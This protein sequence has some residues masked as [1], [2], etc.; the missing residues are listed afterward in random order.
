MASEVGTPTEEQ[1]RAMLAKSLPESVDE[2]TLARIVESAKSQ[3]R[4]DPR[5]LFPERAFFRAVTND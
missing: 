1:L 3:Q 4:Q 2:A 5:P